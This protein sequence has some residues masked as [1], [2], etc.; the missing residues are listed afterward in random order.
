VGSSHQRLAR[1]LL[2]WPRTPLGSYYEH[3]SSDSIFLTAYEFENEL[4]ALPGQ[5]RND[6][7]Q[8]ISANDVTVPRWRLK[9]PC[10]FKNPQTYANSVANTQSVTPGRILLLRGHPT[11]AWLGTIGSSHLVDPEFFRRWLEFSHADDRRN[12]FS[13]PTLPSGGWNLL[14]LPIISIGKREENY[15]FKVQDEI[16]TVRSESATAVR[17]YHN[18][19]YD[20]DDGV[21]GSSVARDLCV[22]DH[23]LF[24]IEQKITICMQPPKNTKGWNRKLSHSTR[25]LELLLKLNSFCMDGCW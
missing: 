16:D 21:V 6:T 15:P 18:G 22:F 3:G 8:R 23:A 24:A 2:S 17:T 7:S 19:L 5:P 10:H 9:A 14:E 12:K 11:P 25:S 13:L 4:E 1:F 20:R